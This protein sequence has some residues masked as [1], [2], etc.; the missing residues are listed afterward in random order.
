MLKQKL[1]VVLFSLISISQVSGQ[2]ELFPIHYTHLSSKDKA[3]FSINSISGNWNE[4]TIYK[5]K[6]R[7]NGPSNEYI[8]NCRQGK[9]DTTIT[10]CTSKIEDTDNRLNIRILDKSL[11]PVRNIPIT[12]HAEEGLPIVRVFPS[13]WV[14]LLYPFDQSYRWFSPS[15]IQTPGSLFKNSRY[16]LEKKIL[17]AN[18]GKVLYTTNMQSAQLENQNSVSIFRWDAG[19]TPDSLGS[20]PV[21]VPYDFQVN[22][23]VAYVLG[24]RFSTPESQPQ[25]RICT[26]D[27]MHH[28]LLNSIPIQGIPRQFVYQK[29]QL[30]CIYDSHIK[31][32]NAVTGESI[33]TIDLQSDRYIQKARLFDKSLRIVTSSIPSVSPS[34]VIYS[35]FEL[36]SINTT[37]RKMQSVKLIIPK[38]SQLH[39][40]FSSKSDR[41]RI[42][43]SDSM[44]E[45]QLPALP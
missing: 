25:S 16:N 34:G 4:K 32:Y 13:R 9:L 43:T 40:L 33:S 23:S 15:G 5:N 17:T 22:G 27:L 29:N 2:T 18:S 31:I 26:F 20:V 42:V 1:L 3:F 44:Y 35:D 36:V 28:T 7:Y 37:D 12:I 39:C 21:T 38:T 41:L 14:L 30:F 19:Q 45:Y 6:F 10:I 11:T 8:I 24:S